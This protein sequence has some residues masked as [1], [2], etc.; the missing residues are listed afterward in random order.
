MTEEDLVAETKEWLNDIY[1]AIEVYGKVF[2]AGDLLHY[3]EDSI[4]LEAMNEY[5]ECKRKGAL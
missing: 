3:F 5:I 2:K 4:F 1:G